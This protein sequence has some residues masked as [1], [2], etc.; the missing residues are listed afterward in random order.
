[1]IE[2]LLGLL[3]E[4]AEESGVILLLL[5]GHWYQWKHV[6]ELK[7]EVADVR[8]ELAE[9]NG[10]QIDWFRKQSTHNRGNESGS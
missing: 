3:A 4:H 2:T 9:I 1:M 7:K 8:K 6:Q 5:I 10:A